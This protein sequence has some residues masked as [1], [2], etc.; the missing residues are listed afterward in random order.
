MTTTPTTAPSVVTPAQAPTVTLTV[1]AENSTITASITATATTTETVQSIATI[2][3]GVSLTTAAD[4]TV[5][6]VETPITG[7]DP[8]PS[9][10][11]S[12]EVTAGIAVA[13]AIAGII[14]GALGAWLVMKVLRKNH[15]RSQR[16]PVGAFTRSLTSRSAPYRDTENAPEKL[17]SASNAEYMMPQALDDNAV[18]DE[19]GKLFGL[20]ED[21]VDSEYYHDRRTKD[22]VSASDCT[23]TLLAAGSVLKDHDITFLLDDQRTRFS[24]M[25]AAIAAELLAAISFHADT[26]KS[27]LP[28]M[29]TS[30]LNTPSGGLKDNHRKY[31]ELIVLLI[32][33]L[34]RYPV[35]YLTMAHEYCISTWRSAQRQRRC[36]SRPSS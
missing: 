3:V 19:V 22:R 31:I 9:G 16:R 29:V 27:L 2:T 36:P 18:R 35:V 14:I 12:S 1:P 24:A 33:N 5:Y 20:I 6:T 30:F 11:I 17:A 21:H 7:A 25:K 10:R 26:N 34:R 8:A 4:G 13:T 23:K 28:E 15:Y 32:T